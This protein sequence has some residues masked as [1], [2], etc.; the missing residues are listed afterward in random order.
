MGYPIVP[1]FKEVFYKKFAHFLERISATSQVI[2]VAEESV[3]IYFYIKKDFY[4]KRMKPSPNS[5]VAKMIL[6]KQEW[7]YY[8]MNGAMFSKEAFTDNLYTAQ[9]PDSARA[10]IKDA[11]IKEK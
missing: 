2:S 9:W 11:M 3:D 7:K 1:T 8:I 10:I 6:T 5:L 4:G